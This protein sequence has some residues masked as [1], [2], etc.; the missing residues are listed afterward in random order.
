MLGNGSVQLDSRAH[1]WIVIIEQAAQVDAGAL[2][3]RAARSEILRTGQRQR[4]GKFLYREPQAAEAAP[5]RSADIDEAKMQARGR[6]NS[7]D[8]AGGTSCVRGGIHRIA[9]EPFKCATMDRTAWLQ[10]RPP[11]H[12]T[13]WRRGPLR[14]PLD[15]VCSLLYW[16]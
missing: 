1:R 6:F 13:L 8:S 5:E 14:E 10:A 2:S 15:T 3:L 7:H 16:M 11:R 4:G 9:L 12:A